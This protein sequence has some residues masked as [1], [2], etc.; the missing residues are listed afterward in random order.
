MIFN[1]IEHMCYCLFNE[2]FMTKENSQR[3]F[4]IWYLSDYMS[5]DIDE[6]IRH[7]YR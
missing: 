5:H 6:R 4:S 7:L 3:V 2:S 1:Y